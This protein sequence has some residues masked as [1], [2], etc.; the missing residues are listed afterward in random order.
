ME[1]DQLLHVYVYVCHLDVEDI[2]HARQLR[3]VLGLDLSQCS[4]YPTN[5]RILS[6]YR[7]VKLAH[8]HD[9]KSANMNEI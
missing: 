2:Q 4:Q 8:T 3:L 9:K 1:H 7:E 5:N 6:Q